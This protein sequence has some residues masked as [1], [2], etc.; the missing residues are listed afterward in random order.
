MVGAYFVDI[1]SVQAERMID[2]TETEDFD[3]DGFPGALHDFRWELEAGTVDC[4]FQTA[5]QGANLYVNFRVCS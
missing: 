1:G 5:S 3:F 4:F 2:G